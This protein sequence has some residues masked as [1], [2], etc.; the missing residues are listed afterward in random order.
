VTRHRTKPS[1]RRR[2]WLPFVAALLV[3]G[4]AA[5]C[6]D[7]DDQP[8]AV[9]SSPSTSGTP[10]PPTSATSATGATT[11]TTTT[12]TTTAPSTTAGTASGSTASTAVPEP[13]TPTEEGA[14]DMVAVTFLGF[15][16][17]GPAEPVLDAALATL[18]DPSRD[19]GWGP[20]ECP[21]FERA[22]ALLWGPLRLD[23]QAVDG[24]DTF[25]GAS[26]NAAFEP[27]PPATRDRVRLPARVEWGMPIADVAS[28]LGAEVSEDPVLQREDVT[29]E[30]AA[31]SGD[32]SAG[33]AVL[34][35]VEIGF[36]PKCR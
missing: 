33:P 3:V 13:P 23:L 5:G 34:D 30:G 35:W 22:R 14:L 4:L 12:A 10:S 17:G 6:G 36:V 1:G 21:V 27:S 24:T 32:A 15:A 29:S 16:P 25:V 28:A 9:T 19:F 8:E 7:D 31:F 18:G 20:T 2:C 11:A 26:Y